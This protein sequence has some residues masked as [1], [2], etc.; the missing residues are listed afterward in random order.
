MLDSAADRQRDQMFGQRVMWEWTDWITSDVGALF[1][2][3]FHKNAWTYK[4][5]K[6]NQNLIMGKGEIV[7]RVI[8]R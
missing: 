4:G 8:N 6:A 1:Q 3:T 5:A 2:V 7:E